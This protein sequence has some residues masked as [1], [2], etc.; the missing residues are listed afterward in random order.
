M[1]QDQRGLVARASS[2]EEP[3]ND[4][5]FLWLFFVSCESNQRFFQG[6]CLHSSR[7]FSG[8]K[9][10]RRPLALVPAPGYKN[11]SFLQ[12]KVVLTDNTDVLTMDEGLVF[13]NVSLCS[14]VS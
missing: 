13:T 5:R 8:L 4:L 7:F 9:D 3:L 2:M 1:L 12:D 10:P 14:H 6:S 11:L